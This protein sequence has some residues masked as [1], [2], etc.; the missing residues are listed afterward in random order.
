[1]TA[2]LAWVERLEEETR[3]M[4]RAD[5]EDGVERKGRSNETGRD[6]KFKRGADRERDCNGA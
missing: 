1:M 3:D 4:V 5:G 6:G 2:E